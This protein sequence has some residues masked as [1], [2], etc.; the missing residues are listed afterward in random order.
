MS[1]QYGLAAKVCPDASSDEKPV[2]MVACG[3]PL[4]VMM[5]VSVPLS[6]HPVEPRLHEP[7]VDIRHEAQSGKS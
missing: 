6:L 1:G 4:A 7:G 5:Y 2:A 3:Y